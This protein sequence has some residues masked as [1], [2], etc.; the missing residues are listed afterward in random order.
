MLTPRYYTPCSA[1]ELEALF[2]HSS[3]IC[4]A[5]V[6]PQT[7]YMMIASIVEHI[8]NTFLVEVD[9]AAIEL[10]FADRDGDVFQVP[11]TMNLIDL[12]D[13]EYPSWRSN[14]AFFDLSQFLPILT[15]RLL[16][17]FRVT[18][19]IR[20]SFSREF[21]CF[22]LQKRTRLDLVILARFSHLSTV[23]LSERFSHLL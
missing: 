13:R 5:D 9:P 6:P 2:T 16:L 15:F 7:I 21:C 19:M 4:A 20:E 14:R 18:F 22:E 8:L 11:R 10:R 17:G 1:L 23:S 12:L 3:L